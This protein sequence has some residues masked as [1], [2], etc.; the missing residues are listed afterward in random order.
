MSRT[1]RALRAVVSDLME[2]VSG[3]TYFV[4]R[5][6]GLWQRYDLGGS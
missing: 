1:A 4:K 6:S 2:T 5:I 3:T